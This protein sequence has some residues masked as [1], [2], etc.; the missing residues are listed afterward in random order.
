MQGANMANLL[1]QQQLQG[2]ISSTVGSQPTSVEQA[3]LQQLGVSPS[4]SSG[5]LLGMLGVG[6]S[7][8]PQWIKN[9]NPFGGSSSSSS[10]GGMN[11]AANIISGLAGGQSSGGLFDDDDGDGVPNYAD[12]Y[13][14]DPTKI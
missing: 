12:N 13:P 4:G 2:L 11:N 5:G 7:P 6:S 1:Q 3:L 9:L 14:T 8:T 10:S